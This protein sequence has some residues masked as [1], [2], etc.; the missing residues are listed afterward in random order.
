MLGGYTIHLQRLTGQVLL[1]GQ[2][3]QTHDHLAAAHHAPRLPDRL[4]IHPGER[5]KLVPPALR[6]PLGI[7]N[8]TTAF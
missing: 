1:A 4:P 8:Q 7:L 6:G 5:R 3:I 2:R